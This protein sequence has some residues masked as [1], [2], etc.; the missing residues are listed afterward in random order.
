MIP[1]MRHPSRLI[2]LLAIVAALSFMATRGRAAELVMYERDGCAWCMRWHQEIGSG[3]PQTDEGRRAPLRVIGSL[4]AAP[5]GVALKSPI[6]VT[7]T[8][9]LADKGVEIGRITGYPG[10]HFFYGLLSELLKKLERSA[11]GS[12]ASGPIKTGGRAASPS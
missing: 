4:A 2:V 6:A 12:P 1:A 9:V 5:A 11:A 8:F 10:S 7:P 3:Y